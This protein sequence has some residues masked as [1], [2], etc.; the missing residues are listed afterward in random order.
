MIVTTQCHTHWPL[1]WFGPDWL[2]Q[3][4]RA[5]SF[6]WYTIGKVHGM[7]SCFIRPV[8]RRGYAHESTPGSSQ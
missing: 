8:I 6:A 2:D 4:R 3:K 5:T 1:V 7:G